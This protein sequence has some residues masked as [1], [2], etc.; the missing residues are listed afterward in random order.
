MES[1]LRL[2]VNLSSDPPSDLVPE[3]SCEVREKEDNFFT[4]CF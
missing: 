2:D 4:S 1:H 3:L